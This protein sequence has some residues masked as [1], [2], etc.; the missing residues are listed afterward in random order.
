MSA[1]S[2]SI[3]QLASTTRQ[4]KEKKSIQTGKEES[5]QPLFLNGVIVYVKKN[6][7]ES[8]KKELSERITENSKVVE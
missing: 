2:P 7:M 4:E 6:P 8:S 1:L 5:K 3:V